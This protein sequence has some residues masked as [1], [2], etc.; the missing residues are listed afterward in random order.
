MDNRL[1]LLPE[2]VA[3]LYDAELLNVGKYGNFHINNRGYISVSL[4]GS[5]KHPFLHRV[6]M[7]EYLG[8]PLLR[9]E[10]VHHKNHNPLDNRIE[11]L[12]VVSEE[13]HRQ[14]HDMVAGKV[15]VS[16]PGCGKVRHF[17][18]SH[19]L[20][21]KDRTCINC[22][23]KKANDLF[24]GHI[25]HFW[26][27]FEPVGLVGPFNSRRELNENRPGMLKKNYAPITYNTREDTFFRNAGRIPDE[28]KE[29]IRQRA[30]KGT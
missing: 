7:E 15:A 14:L 23:S 5:S 2:N 18:Y 17:Y 26:F 24:T 20:D 8:R 25:I 6:L 4:R 22:R 3:V 19:S 28:A 29:L 21:A 1:S 11:N 9:A 30:A 10:I 16:C 13:E 27:I 12:Q